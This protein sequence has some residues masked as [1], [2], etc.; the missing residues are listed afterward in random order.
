MAAVTTIPYLDAVSEPDLQ[1]TVLTRGC[2][3]V[4]YFLGV[5]CVLWRYNG[6]REFELVCREQLSIAVRKSHH[7]LRYTRLQD[8][9]GACNQQTALH[10]YLRLDLLLACAARR[11]ALKQRALWK[12]RIVKTQT[13]TCTEISLCYSERK[14]RDFS[15]LEHRHDK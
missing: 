3:K 11:S 10:V 13:Q 5:N 9:N 14:L 12:P 6:E 8:E 15:T 7:C 4:K 1:F 2:A